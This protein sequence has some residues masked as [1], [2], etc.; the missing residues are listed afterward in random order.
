MCAW[1]LICLMNWDDSYTAEMRWITSLF[2][3]NT[4]KRGNGRSS[5]SICFRYRTGI[6]L[7]SIKKTLENLIQMAKTRNFSTSKR[8]PL[9]ID[10]GCWVEQSNLFTYFLSCLTILCKLICPLWP[11]ITLSLNSFHPALLRTPKQNLWL[12]FTV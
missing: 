11:Q 9:P 2:K 4:R 1:V 12:K 8:M 3:H 7:L 5:Y 6:F 10:H